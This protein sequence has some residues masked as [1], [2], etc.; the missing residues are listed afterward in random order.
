MANI[1]DIPAAFL[2]PQ[3]LNIEDYFQQISFNDE[4]VASFLSAHGHL[5]NPQDEQTCHRCNGQMK[6]ITRRQRN[7]N[8]RVVVR[9]RRKGC[10]TYR[11]TREGRTHCFQYT[12][13]N[14]RTNCNLSLSDILE[15]IYFF[16]NSTS[17]GVWRK[18]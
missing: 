8:P 15:M 16:V 3:I 10:A 14:G 2:N 18:T 4:Q 17:I 13:L 9:C 11:S 7:G 6:A 5:V 1:R 12:D